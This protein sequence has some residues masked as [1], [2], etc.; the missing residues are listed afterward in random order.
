M[1][2]KDII[3]IIK[4]IESSKPR[5][6]SMST[7]G[8]NLDVMAHQLRK[9]GLKRVNISLHSLQESRFRRLSGLNR[10]NKTI[11]SIKKAIEADLTPVKINVTILKGINYDE[12][13]NFVEFSRT[14]GGGNTNILQFIELVPNGSTNFAQ[15][16]YS[17]DQVE[18]EIKGRAL[19]LT[20]RISHRRPKY[21][22][23]NGVTVE[24]VR[25]M[26]NTRFC[27]G[28]NRLRITHDGKFKPC[29]LRNDNHLDFLSPMRYGVEDSQIIELLKKGISQR[30]PFFKGQKEEEEIHVDSASK[31]I[32]H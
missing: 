12:I 31:R 19:A 14:I 23:D 9:T 26:H 27:M 2:R 7:N 6:I 32:D 29:L 10:L 25:P 22:L 24:I 21:E 3:E 28:C 8:T 15:Y 30:E 11:E 18:E 1:L 20:E 16:H 17:L 5:E 13:E 4:R